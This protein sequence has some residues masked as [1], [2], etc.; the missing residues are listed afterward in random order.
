M[1]PQY[2]TPYEREVL[3]DLYIRAADMTHDDFFVAERYDAWAM[4]WAASCGQGQLTEFEELYGWIYFSSRFGQEVGKA[5]ES[6][7][8]HLILCFLLA[9]EMLDDDHLVE[10][11][12]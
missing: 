6:D 5:K 1:R 12:E 7:Q 2:L 10:V 4:I 11:P 8:N 3:R 9:T